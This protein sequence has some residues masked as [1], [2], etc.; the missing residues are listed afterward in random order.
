[1][2]Y[3]SNNKTVK[4]RTRKRILI[5]YIIVGMLFGVLFPIFSI[6]YELYAMQLDATFA[7]LSIVYINNPLLYIISTA[8]FFLGLFSFIAGI[9]QADVEDEKQQIE[10]KE[11]E[12]AKIAYHDSLTGLP[13]RVLLNER[14]NLILALAHRQKKS[15]AVI[16][17]DLDNFKT[18]NDKFGHAIGD[19]VIIETAKRINNIMRH[20]DTIS[21]LGGDE[22]IAVVYNHKGTSGVV[23]VSEKIINCIAKPFKIN[24]Q[25][26]SLSVSIGIALYPTDGEDRE[27]LMKNADAAMYRAKENGKNRFEF[28]SHL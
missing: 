13:N 12:I 6:V 8:P 21:R 3:K 1:M 25:N 17:I 14:F 24:E 9:K 23:N 20:E 22:F 28:F 10:I 7:S 11:K 26:V 16:F 2:D 19:E 4:S 27:S 5:E 18:V 15:A